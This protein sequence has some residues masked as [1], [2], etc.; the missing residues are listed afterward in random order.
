MVPLLRGRRPVRDLPHILAQAGGSVMSLPA[1]SMWLRAF[2][3]VAY[4]NSGGWLEDI[5]YPR[6]CKPIGECVG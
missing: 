1:L 6:R 4:C 2:A 5:G 3:G